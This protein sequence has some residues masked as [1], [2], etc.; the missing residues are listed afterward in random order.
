MQSEA[1]ADRFACRRAAEVVVAG[2]RAGR[3]ENDLELTRGAAQL[4]RR[5][6]TDRRLVEGDGLPVL[7]DSV[8]VFERELEAAKVLDVCA[9]TRDSRLNG[10]PPIWA[11]SGSRSQTRRPFRRD[12]SAQDVVGQIE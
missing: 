5:F 1:F 3:L 12:L 10:N 11:E 9:G 6:V 7:T 2:A 4:E 8:E